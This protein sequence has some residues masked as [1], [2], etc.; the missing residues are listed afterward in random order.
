L[1]SENGT[2]WVA[3]GASFGLLGVALGAFGAHALK[4]SLTLES[5]AVYETAVHYHQL[6]AV[7]L[8]AIGILE[9]QRGRSRLTNAAGWLTVAGIA[10]FSGTLYALAVTG[11]RWLGA[12]TPAGG[13]S[14]MLGWGCLAASALKQKS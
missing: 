2:R 8:L 13:L 5:K 1:N 4:G 3:I 6:H 14:L 7:L 10:V 12:I 11:M 9:L